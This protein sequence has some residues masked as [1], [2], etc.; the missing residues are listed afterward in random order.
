MMRKPWNQLGLTP[1]DYEINLIAEKEGM[2]AWKAKSHVIMKWMKA[3]DFR[4]LLAQIR[5]EGVLRGPALGLLV[6]M[7]ESG[8]LMFRKGRGH[9]N[10][11]EAGARDEFAADTYEEFL[12]DYEVK[13]SSD[14]LFRTIGSVVGTGEESVRQAVK[15]RRR[16]AKPTG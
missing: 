10:D 12:K 11:P 5:K 2:D 9:P 6:Q 1:W 14:D 15:T 3:G 7:I 13:V 16:K 8:E 4:P